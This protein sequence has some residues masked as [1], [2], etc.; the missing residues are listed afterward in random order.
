MDYPKWGSSPLRGCFFT[1]FAKVVHRVKSQFW[2]SLKLIY[3]VSLPGL[4]LHVRRYLCSMR[5]KLCH[6]AP[7]LFPS[8]VWLL[9]AVVTK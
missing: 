9:T 7:L 6:M 4:V 1:V 8:L 2:S 3:M 5:D